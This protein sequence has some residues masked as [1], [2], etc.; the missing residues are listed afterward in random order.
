MSTNDTSILD[1]QRP[2]KC[3][4]VESKESIDISLERDLGLRLQIW[5]H[6]VN[7][8]DE[9]RI[10]YIK[11]GAFQPNL[12][13]YPRSKS[14]NQY[15][16]FQHSWFKQF[17]WLEYSPSKDRAFCFP[18]FIFEK[19]LAIHPAFTIEGFKSWKR[20]NDGD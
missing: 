11:V 8:S 16:R 19:N 7:L 10:T 5:Q 17:P 3:R 18:C 4:R 20:V 14:G 2:T 13:E 1:E 9:I 15:R 12:P 6:P